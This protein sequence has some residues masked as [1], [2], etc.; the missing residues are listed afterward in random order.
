MFACTSSQKHARILQKPLRKNTEKVKENLVFW[1]GDSAASSHAGLTQKL[2]VPKWVCRSTLA[3]FCHGPPFF[4][5]FGPAR[6]QIFAKKVEK[7]QKTDGF[8][9]FLCLL[10]RKSYRNACKLP[11]S[12]SRASLVIFTSMLRV[13]VVGVVSF[14]G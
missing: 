6:G 5:I 7:Y 14:L 11:Y 1:S 12:Q 8:L 4:A 13:S 9:S 10:Y 2:K 3:S